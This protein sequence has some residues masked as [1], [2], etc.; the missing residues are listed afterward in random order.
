[1]SYLTEHPGLFSATGF[2]FLVCLIGLFAYSRSKHLLPLMAAALALVIIPLVIDRLVETDQE[3]LKRRIYEMARCVSYNDV[4]GL[5]KYVDPKAVYTISQ[6]ESEMPT[7]EFS[8][9]NVMKFNNIFIAEDQSEAQ[10]TFLVLVNV[11]A[12]NYQNH[13]GLAN[14]LVRLDFK[15]D[16][17]EQWKVTKLDHD[18]PGFSSNF[19]RR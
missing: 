17:N 11:H 5:L 16:D 2:F 18:P 13:H 6:I 12:P 14:R 7:F 10:V 9:C 1:M 19:V 15:R 3:Q 4:N 8:S